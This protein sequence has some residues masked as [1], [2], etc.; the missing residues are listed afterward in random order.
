MYE[1]DYRR[2]SCSAFFKNYHIVPSISAA[3]IGTSVLSLVSGAGGGGGG[4]SG[5]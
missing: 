5:I 4:G 3:S 2:N 1:H